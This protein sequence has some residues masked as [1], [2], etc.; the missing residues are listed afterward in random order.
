MSRL[1]EKRKK[2]DKSDMQNKT[3]YLNPVDDHRNTSL[4]ESRPASF[5][6][7]PILSTPIPPKHRV[8]NEGE[9]YDGNLPE[10]Y[11]SR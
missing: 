4:L 5:I 3:Q 2:I 1:T 8:C 10:D 9:K 11:Y 6:G 7:I